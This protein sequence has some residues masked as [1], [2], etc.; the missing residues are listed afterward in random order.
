MPNAARGFTLIEV[1]IAVAIVAVLAS[2]A[3]PAYQESVRKGRRAEAFTALAALQQAQERWRGNNASYTTELVNTA[4]AGTPPNGLGLAAT[5]QTGYYG[6]AVSD[7]SATG[8]TVTATAAIGTSQ[9][10]D[11]NCKVLGVKLDSGAIKY[12]SGASSIT[13]TATNPDAGKCWAK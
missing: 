1:M 10:N 11:G 2:V 3:F 13:W 8:Y 5:T 7:Q 4:A 12:G 9:A 6:I